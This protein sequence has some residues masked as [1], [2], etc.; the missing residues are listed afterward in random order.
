[1]AVNDPR[2]V[3]IPFSPKRIRDKMSQAQKVNLAAQAGVPVNRLV[4]ERTKYKNIINKR[5]QRQR[6]QQAKQ[7]AQRKAQRA[8]QKR[9]TLINVIKVGE[10]IRKRAQEARQTNKRAKSAAK[11]MKLTKAQ[12]VA[13]LKQ[14]KINEWSV[15]LTFEITFR[16]AAGSEPVV[17]PK[18]INYRTKDL[19]DLNMQADYYGRVTD[20]W[21][22]KG[23]VRLVGQNIIQVDRS[24]NVSSIP[25]F[26]S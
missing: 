25:M 17:V 15:T 2:A 26:S 12:R 9:Q 21:Y 22:K 3:L 4:A 16:G 8:Q 13:G 18:T 14:Q 7:K 6:E 24:M 11:A 5:A 1:M 10:Q 23:E 20:E 19:G